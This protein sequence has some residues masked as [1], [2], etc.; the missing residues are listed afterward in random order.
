MPN[1]RPSAK[2]VPADDTAEEKV[3]TE[4]ASHILQD[5]YLGGIRPNWLV[6]AVRLIEERRE[7]TSRDSDRLP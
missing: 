1:E 7:R 3:M 4:I 2:D 6:T 5:R